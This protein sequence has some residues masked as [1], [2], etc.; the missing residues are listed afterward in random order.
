MRNW[1]ILAFTFFALALESQGTLAFCSNEGL[2]PS[3]TISQN[4]PGVVEGMV[5]DAKSKEPIPNVAI[6]LM[7]YS[8]WSDEDLERLGGP[9]RYVYTDNDGRYSIKDLPE[10][11]YSLKTSL[12][13]YAPQTV[14]K[15]H[16]TQSGNT[17]S[18]NLSLFPSAHVPEIVVNDPHRSDVQGAV[19]DFDTGEPIEDAILTVIGEGKCTTT[20]FEGTYH[21][22][23][24]RRSYYD[25]RIEK[26]GYHAITYHNVLLYFEKG[27]VDN[28]LYDRS[29]K[30][31][32][33][34]MYLSRRKQ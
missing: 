9:Y 34:N 5:I 7:Q 4:T 13:G 10:G 6:H 14:D 25:L 33:I 21:L 1:M 12:V 3:F 8:R 28:P 29:S 23:N 11:Y 15:I 19:Y 26:H 2:H 27:M 22:D 30:T 32:K 20:S 31:W 24:L 17:V 16:V 18:L